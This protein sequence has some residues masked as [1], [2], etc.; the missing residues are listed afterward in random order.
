MILF[1]DTSVLIPAFQLTHEQHEA[2][3]LAL[4]QSL[5]HSAACGA[6]TLAEFYSVLTRLPAPHR[7]D[8]DQ[9]FFGIE[10]IAAHFQVVS[11]NTQEYL[12]EIKSAAAARIPGGQIYDFLL[13][14][15]ARKAKA[16]RILTWNLK[17]FRHLA[18]D[19]AERIVTP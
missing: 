3:N 17:H 6:H 10:Q 14:A 7:L 4:A 2:S 18:P 13:L 15:C 16:D 5:K 19:L 11:L 1:F 8:P 12:S 9:A